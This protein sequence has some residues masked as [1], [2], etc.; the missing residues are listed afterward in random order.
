MIQAE[1]QQGVGR[2]KN[3]V[4]DYMIRKLLFP[5]AISTRTSMV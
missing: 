5:K 4:Q 2:A 1:M 3:A